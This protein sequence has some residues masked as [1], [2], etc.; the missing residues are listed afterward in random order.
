[1]KN[2]SGIQAFGVHLR[3]LREERGMSQQELADLA[4]VSKMTVLRAEN[5]R[6]TVTLDV[7]LSLSRALQV[8]LPDLMGFEVPEEPI[9]GSV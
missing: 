7:L 3:R 6:H 1:M 9:R 2:P 5:A 4:D 8:P